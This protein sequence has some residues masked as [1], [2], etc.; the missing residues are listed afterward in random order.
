M[1]PDFECRHTRRVRARMA[2]SADSAR[3]VCAICG[4]R[5]DAE[6][7]D[8]CRGCDQLVCQ[9]CANRAQSALRQSEGDA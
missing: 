3:S 6:A 4:A 7:G 2:F 1:T 9:R 5:C 8:L